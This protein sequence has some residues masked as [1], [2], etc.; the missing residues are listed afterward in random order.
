MVTSL[1]TILIKPLSAEG[2]AL[3]NSLHSEM[4]GLS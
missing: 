2:I 1:R 3:I 4:C